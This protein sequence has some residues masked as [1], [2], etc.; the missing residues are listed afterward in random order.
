MKQGKNDSIVNQKQRGQNVYVVYPQQN[1]QYVPLPQLQWRN[2]YQE[3]QQRNFVE[4]ER[5][6]KI[7]QRHTRRNRIKARE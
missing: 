1:G 2:S 7:R 3:M 5:K 6:K 4:N